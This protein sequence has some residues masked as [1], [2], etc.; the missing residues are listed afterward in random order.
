MRSRRKRA[1]WIDMERRGRDERKQV[2]WNGRKV[3]KLSASV[4]RNTIN[5]PQGRLHPHEPQI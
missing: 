2:R 3:L 1:R 5:K 4:L